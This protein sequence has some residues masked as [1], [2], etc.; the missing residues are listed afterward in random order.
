MWGFAAHIT[1]TLLSGS[2]IKAREIS[3]SILEFND[4]LYVSLK[5]S[6]RTQVIRPPVIIT[7]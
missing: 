4:M 5:G 3:C 1:R 7:T 6:I 2:L